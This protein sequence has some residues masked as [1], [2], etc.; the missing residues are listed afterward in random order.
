MKEELMNY[1][2]PKIVAVSFLIGS[3]NFAMA[4][5][6]E[7]AQPSLAWSEPSDAAKIENALSAGPKFITDDAAVM[8]WPT[9]QDKDGKMRVL[10]QGSN[11]WTCMPDRPAPRHNPMCA[12]ETMMKW[13]MAMMIGKKP[14]IGRIGISYM[15]Q[16]EAGADV[17][18]IN[19][20]APPD[21]KNWYYV[22]PHIMLVLPDSDKDALKDVGQ[23]TSSGMPYVRG[24]SAPSPLL[25]IPV[26]KPDEQIAVR[27]AP[28]SK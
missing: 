26:A 22:G 13:M 16:G 6:H 15:L 10:R 12:D 1:R 27:K 9:A 20:K 2:V 18:D 25:V 4:Q 21:G 24:P 3:P 28:T 11:G 17:Q 23:D 5:E 14:N 8:D 19:A 7:P